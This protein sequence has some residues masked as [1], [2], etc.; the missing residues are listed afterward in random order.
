MPK[1]IEQVRQWLVEEIKD[2]A[3]KEDMANHGFAAMPYYAIRTTLEKLL[4]YID[5]EKIDENT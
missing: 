3:G 4:D 2:N 5:S 1:T